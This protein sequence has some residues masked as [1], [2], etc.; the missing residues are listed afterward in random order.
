MKKSN[1]HICLC[2]IIFL[3]FFA[4][5][6]ACNNLT[7][8][9]ENQKQKNPNKAYLKI[10]ID[11]TTL[12]RTALPS[13]SRDSIKGFTFTIKGTTQT[14]PQDSDW[15]TLGTFDDTS[16]SA[17]NLDS[18]EHASLEVETGDWT[19]EL[20]AEKDGT[21]LLAQATATIESGEN[22]IN[23]SLEWD[24]SALD[25]TKTG[26]LSFTVDF[27]QAS[28]AGDITFVTGQLYSYDIQSSTASE[29]TGENASK[30]QAKELTITASKAT[31]SLE[32]IPAGNYKI[33]ILLYVQDSN[34]DNT[35]PIQI[36]A[37]LHELAIITGGQESSGTRSINS[38]NELYTIGWNNLDGANAPNTLP[39][40]YSRFTD[41]TLPQTGISKTGYSFG[42]WYENASLTGNAVTSI[43][44]GS[45]GT[46]T[47]YAK[48]NPNSDTVYTV[49]HWKQKRN[50]GTTH[51]STN[52]ELSSTNGIDS[53]TGYTN[54]AVTFS[55]RDVTSG[56][57]LGYTTPSAEEIAAAEQIT[58]N[59]AGDTVVDLYYNLRPCTVTY[60]DNVEGETISVP[61][62]SNVYYVGD[63]ASILSM[64]PTR[65]GYTFRGWSQKQEAQSNNDIL[66]IGGYD[67]FP[68]RGDDVI[69]YA[70]WVILV[71]FETNG[72]SAI[73]A[74]MLKYGDKASRPKNNPT[75]ENYSFEGWYFDSDL[76]DE[77]DFNT[78][79][80]QNITLYAKW[81]F[82]QFAKIN[83]TYYATYDQ[84]MEALVDTLPRQGVKNIDITLYSPSKNGCSPQMIG[85]P[86][87]GTSTS[88][89]LAA[90][91]YNPGTPVYNTV[92]FTIDKDAGIVFSGDEL[93]NRFAG[94]GNIVSIDLS[95]VILD[96]VTTLNQIFKGCNI[97][98]TVT[99][100]PSFNTSTISIMNGMFLYDAMLTKVD[101][102]NL[103]TTNVTTMAGIFQD[104]S[105]LKVLDLS[106]FRTN[107]TT[108]Y[109]NMFAN[110]TNLSI[111]LASEDFVVLT[112]ALDTDM[113]AGCTK[114]KGGMGTTWNSLYTS[115]DYA[116]LDGGTTNPGYFTEKPVSGL[117]TI[118]FETA[119]GTTI[120]SQTVECG[121]L[122]ENPGEPSKEG[123]IFEGWFT[124]TAYTEP[125]DLTDTPIIFDTTIYAKWESRSGKFARINGTYYGSMSA[126]MDAIAALSGQGVTDATF[127]LYETPA[128]ED[129][130]SD[131][132]EVIGK[133]NSSSNCIVKALKTSGV[134]NVTFVIDKD[135][136][137]VFRGDQFAE[138]F[139]G[140][141]NFVSIDLSGII[142]ATTGGTPAEVMDNLFYADENLK[143][144]IFPDNLDTS[145][146]LS[147]V[148]MFSN[149]RSLQVVDI[150]MFNTVNVQSMR[151]L[152]YADENLTTI[153]ASNKFITTN[154]INDTDM[155]THCDKLVGG[156]GSKYSVTQITGK[157]GA[158][159]DGGQKNPGYFT[160]KDKPSLTCSVGDII[161]RD[162]T[163]IPYS[164]SLELNTEQQR[165]AI[166]VIFYD[167]HGSLGGKPLGVGIYQANTSQNNPLIMM[168]SKAEGSAIVLNSDD[169]SGMVFTEAVYG[170]SDY[171]NEPS[172]GYPVFNWLVNYFKVVGG[173]LDGTDYNDNWYLPS[174]NELFAIKDNVDIINSALQKI[175]NPDGGLFNTTN[176]YWA[177]YQ[178]TT[179]EGYTGCVAFGKSGSEAWSEIEKGNSKIGVYACA[180]HEF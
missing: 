107:N 48:W 47:F 74:Q 36:M 57:F 84:T 137:L 70:Q 178:S 157:E 176:N 38:F 180:I 177:A 4:C 69:L 114:L 68:I 64:E 65:P 78:P 13:F 97:L 54:A 92:A 144:V 21:K 66:K 117:A 56:A 8:S 94:A 151:S 169:N 80:T 123:Y 171:N 96:Q 141:T 143:T 121:E 17:D 12:S 30:Y 158:K 31:Y 172:E 173:V 106:N 131:L 37:P 33:E 126:T 72:G 82:A 34:T 3:A 109:S 95:G 159:I 20:T 62:D 105:S 103:N 7:G 150:S 41:Y 18:L 122:A 138:M 175:N 81:K 128:N 27:S 32:E 147:M 49:N 140:C 174:K 111:I 11:D 75:K 130:N 102:Y 166:A 40:N 156:K 124:D 14:N 161:L 119:G 26:S 139:S 85:K 113:F 116:R 120:A 71:T 22:P 59:A 118:T 1:F 24:D 146:I 28:N 163:V 125:F 29:I 129:Q 160:K 112:S 88:S 52:Y 153:Y 79:I 89:I 83:G 170:L 25:A 100:G 77:F 61:V 91:C 93:E 132:L 154:V 168:N 55:V 142:L 42:G 67:A 5:F 115:K 51:N 110:C 87:G 136:G 53:L 63:T 76:N 6:S 50:G 164:E 19:F 101:L 2:S 165:T 23:F 10:N 15:E 58:I 35:S 46:K 133:G 179:N 127:V 98:T 90:L 45:T 44:A 145:T 167:G 108:D 162:G 99:L 148:N 16:A 39:L 9:Y 104:C 152:F 135:V 134:Q 73:E 86:S 60:V 149:C 43:S 155:F